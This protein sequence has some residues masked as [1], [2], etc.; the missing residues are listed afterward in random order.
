MRAVWRRRTDSADAAFI[1]GHA[2]RVGCRLR[3]KQSST[4]EHLKYPVDISSTCSK[5]QL[6][7]IFCFVCFFFIFFAPFD[8]IQEFM[9][10]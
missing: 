1:L 5:D 9:K 8:P 3:V 7:L 2:I 6:V 10:L 4:T